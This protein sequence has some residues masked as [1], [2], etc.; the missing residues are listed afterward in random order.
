MNCGNT[1]VANCGYSMLELWQPLGGKL[2]QQYVW[3]VETSEWQTKAT[4]CL[5]YG[6]TWMANERQHYVWTMATSERQTK[7]KLR[8]QNVW[9]V[10]TPVWHIMTT[11]FWTREHLR[12]KLRQQYVWTVAHPGPD[13]SKKNPLAHWASKIF[14]HLPSSNSYLPRICVAQI[15]IC[16][17]FA[18]RNRSPTFNIAL[19][20]LWKQYS[21]KSQIIYRKV[22]F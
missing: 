8:Q 17:R 1:W 3:T 4:V 21:C 2:R 6:N 19:T 5:S 22:R 16:P 20:S 11:V 10:T 7:A 12:G 15:P 14:F 18:N 9:T 13:K